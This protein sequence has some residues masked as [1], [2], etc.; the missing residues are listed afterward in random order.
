MQHLSA[1]KA[2][3]LYECVDL[4]PRSRPEADV[5]VV[6]GP[7]RC[8]DRAIVKSG[9]TEERFPCDAGPAAW[10]SD[11]IDNDGNGF[12]DYPDDPG[13]FSP[14]DNDEGFD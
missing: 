13:C 12:I 7:T 4:R 2:R 9:T 10:C 14:D 5:D 6:V 8:I 1:P 11:G 3:H